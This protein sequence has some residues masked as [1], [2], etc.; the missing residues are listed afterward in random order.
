MA[1][2]FVE[3]DVKNGRITGTYLGGKGAVPTR[4]DACV[5]FTRGVYALALGFSSK[6]GLG[7][8]VPHIKVDPDCDECG[9]GANGLPLNTGCM[10]GVAA[11]F[12]AKYRAILYKVMAGA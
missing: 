12:L 1:P 7:G 8:P 3:R 2:P 9:Q 11:N 6:L 10:P 4:D 5:E